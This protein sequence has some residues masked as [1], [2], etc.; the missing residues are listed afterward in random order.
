MLTAFWFVASTFDKNWKTVQAT[1]HA[2]V[3]KIHLD[4]AQF[5]SN[6]AAKALQ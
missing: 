4:G 1:T 3:E 2:I 5:R 6:S